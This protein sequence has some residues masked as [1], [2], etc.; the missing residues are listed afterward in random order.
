M[1]GI[2]DGNEVILFRTY[3][4]VLVDFGV[5]Q[6]QFRNASIVTAVQCFH[7]VRLCYKL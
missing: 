7:H 6:L 5:S 1:F 3:F 4:Y 2:R